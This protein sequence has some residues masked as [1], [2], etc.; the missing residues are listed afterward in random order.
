MNYLIAI[1]TKEQQA[2][3]I[4]LEAS[5]SHTVRLSL[6]DASTEL[7]ADCSIESLWHEAD[8]LLEGSRSGIEFVKIA[9]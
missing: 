1:L 2:A 6:G 3:G 8:Q 7:S 5:G 9:G 4:E